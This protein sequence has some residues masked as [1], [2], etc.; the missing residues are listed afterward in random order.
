MLSLEYVRYLQTWHPYTLKNSPRPRGPH[1]GLVYNAVY[2]VTCTNCEVTARSRKIS[3]RRCV[4]M[5]R[6]L[7]LNEHNCVV[8]GECQYHT[9]KTKKQRLTSTDPFNCHYPD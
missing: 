2:L 6:T 4:L 9:A 1:V 5:V 3:P 8:T 7:A